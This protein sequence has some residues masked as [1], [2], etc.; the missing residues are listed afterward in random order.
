MKKVCAILCCTLLSSV[1]LTPFAEGAKAAES[2]YIFDT[3]KDPFEDYLGINVL[4]DSETKNIFQMEEDGVMYEFRETVT[5]TNGQEEINIE[6]YEVNGVERTLVDEYSTLLFEDRDSNSIIVQDETG[7]RVS[8]SY[9][10]GEPDYL[11]AP[12]ASYKGSYVSDVRYRYTSS[13][14]AQAIMAGQSPY[15]KNVS[16]SNI[17]FVR[18]QGHADNL[19]AYEKNL[20][21]FGVLGFADDV[22]R[23]VRA[24]KVLSY[25]L[26]RKIVKYTV[27]WSPLAAVWH[28]YTYGREWT[29]ARTDY[30]RI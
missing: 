1:L 13:T 6:K 17:N 8:I 22:I 21:T 20:V 14:Q 25:S 16:R 9:D 18:F 19:R 29:Y 23:A 4:V 3:V 24:G 30:R 5:T 11:V 15:Y 28:L 27:R 26:I 10:L 2:D 7:E 12:D